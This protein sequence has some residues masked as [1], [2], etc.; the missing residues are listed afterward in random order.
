[1]LRDSAEQQGKPVSVP[2]PV[3]NHVAFGLTPR[4]LQ[5]DARSVDELLNFIDG[6]EGQREAVAKAKQK[7][8]KG[9]KRGKG[10]PAD[11]QGVDDAAETDGVQA[12]SAAANASRCVHGRLHALRCT[13]PLT[14]RRDADREPWLRERLRRSSSQR[15][16]LTT[17]MGSWAPTSSPRCWQSW[18]WRWR[19]SHAGSTPRPHSRALRRRRRLPR[20]WFLQTV[21]RLCGRC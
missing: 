12:A 4:V 19:S 20:S 5:G 17:M 15:T 18:T 11:E 13:C 8:K 6:E 21:S 1:M 10:A 2:A 7:K 9:K 14:L 16:G 3:L